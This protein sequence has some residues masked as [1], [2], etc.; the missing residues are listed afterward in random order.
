M[1]LRFVVVVELVVGMTVVV[2]TGVVVVA[3]VVLLT[4]EELMGLQVLQT[5]AAE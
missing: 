3:L 5:A 2:G 1:P 4:E